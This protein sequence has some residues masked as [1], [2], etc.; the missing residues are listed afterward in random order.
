MLLMDAAQLI[1]EYLMP[2]RKPSALY[3][4]IITLRASREPN[5]VKVW[6]LHKHYYEKAWTWNNYINGWI[7]S[8]VSDVF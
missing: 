6:I 7:D 8:F 3:E 4:R 1:A 5:P 2:V